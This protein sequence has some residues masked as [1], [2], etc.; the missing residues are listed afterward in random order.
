MTLATIPPIALWDL[1][2]HSTQG[3]VVATGFVMD[4]A[5]EAAAYIFDV[6]KTG[7]LNKIAFYVAAHTTGATLECEVQTISATT[8]LPTGTKVGSS[9]TATVATIT[10]RKIILVPAAT[11]TAT[12]KAALSQDGTKVYFNSGTDV[13]TRAS[14]KLLVAPA[15]GLAEQLLAT[16]PT[17]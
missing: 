14:V 9:T 11:N 2:G 13:V 6:T 12:T 3:A 10:G 5:N 8:G 7:T 4:A 17:L 1:C 16:S 15:T